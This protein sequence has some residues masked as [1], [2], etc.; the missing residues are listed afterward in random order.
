M[1]ITQLNVYP[2]K[3]LRG[4]AL[5][6]AVLE[7]R[8]LAYDRQWMVVDDAGRFVTQ[9]QLP[10][11]AQVSV[12]L[13]ADS[14]VLE[15]PE[16]ESLAIELARSDRP[17]L[18]AYVWDDACQAL[19]E[20]EEAADW[21]T[22]VLGELRGSRLRLVRFAAPHRRRVADDFLRP[23]DVAHTAFADG[24][25]FLVT[26]E[27]SLTALNEVLRAKGLSP[28]PMSRFRPNIVVQGALPF[29]ENGWD[30]LSAAAGHIRLGIRKPCQRCKI[31]TVDQHSGEIAVPGEPLRT[32][33]AMNTV[34]AP[35]GYFGQN[36]ILLAGE[37]ATMAL[38][39]SLRAR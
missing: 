29:A 27:A 11:M 22:G 4:I 32:L 15:H 2:V 33:V 9:R 17:R 39:D 6:R 12:S 38:G 31:T 1:K 24:F 18:T 28:V 34:A 36:A 10:R 5:E 13:E 7:P 3:S 20:G 35:G 21:L 8:G 26:S 37:G 19:D 23:G 30:T 14:L 16:A 25:P